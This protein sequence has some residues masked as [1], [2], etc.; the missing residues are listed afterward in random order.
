MTAIIKNRPSTKRS[1]IE[2]NM[3]AQRETRPCPPRRVA[4]NE[5]PKATGADAI[6]RLGP[7]HIN[8]CPQQNPM[9]SPKPISGKLQRNKATLPSMICFLCSQVV[10]TVLGRRKSWS[11]HLLLLAKS[12]QAPN[13]S[14]HILSGCRCVSRPFN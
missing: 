8:E 13:I 12:R 11:L 9:H 7:S 10:Y 6:I 14:C 1:S 2:L 4:K 5:T 3:S